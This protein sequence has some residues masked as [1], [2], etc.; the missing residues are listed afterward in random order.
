MRSRSRLVLKVAHQFVFNLIGLVLQILPDASWGNRAR[1]AVL[2]LFLESK[3]RN[4]QVSKS[5]HILYPNN[6][7]VGNDVYV[8][9]GAWINAQGGLLIGDETMIGPY[10]AI[11]TGDHSRVGDSFRFG[12][13]KKR[14]VTIGK[15]AWLSAHVAVVAG[16]EIA[17][18]TLVGAGGV[19]V[20][21]I[22]EPGVYGGVPAKRIRGFDHQTGAL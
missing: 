21:S 5:A 10:V 15:G 19:V 4:L 1:G 16:V 2:G 9:Y 18:G 7:E 6:I 20:A 3:G 17:A 12:E 11:S 8:G 14:P 13:H 22:G